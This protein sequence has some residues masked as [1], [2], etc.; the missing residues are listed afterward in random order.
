M[1]YTRQN[2][3]RRYGKRR[4]ANVIKGFLK[5]LE[6]CLIHPAL[7]IPRLGSK[8]SLKVL[9]LTARRLSRSLS[10][11]RSRRFQPRHTFSGVAMPTPLN[12]QLR[13]QTHIRQRS[14]IIS[15][16]SMRTITPKRIV[17]WSFQHS[18][19]QPTPSFCCNLARFTIELPSMILFL[20]STF[21]E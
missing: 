9:S 8:A 18:S 17:K 12:S 10:M 15:S 20:S 19:S 11:F 5:I 14:L 1:E 13:L 3:D 2:L 4:L 21:T 16:V 6:L 7:Y